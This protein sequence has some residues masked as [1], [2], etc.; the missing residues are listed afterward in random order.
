VTAWVGVVLLWRSA[1]VT[2]DEAEARLT[3]FRAAVAHHAPELEDA[4][5][6]TLDLVVGWCAPH[7]AL[8]P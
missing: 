8:F 7:R 3:R 4:V 6:D 1:G 5:L 2:R